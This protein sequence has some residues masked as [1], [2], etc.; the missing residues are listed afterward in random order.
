[1]ARIRRSRPYY[2]KN[3]GV[4]FSGG[5]P[6]LQAAFLA[7]LCDTC[8]AEGI[9]TAI[10]TAGL[11]LSSA[12]E[13]ALATCGL[14]LLDIKHPDPD[15]FRELTGASDR[16]MRDA[17]AFT[18]ANH[19]PTWIRQVIVPGWNDTPEDIEALAELV[20]DHPSRERVELLPYHTMGCAKWQALGRTSPF[21]ETPALDPDALASLQATLDRLLS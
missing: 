13:R 17:L 8:A 18:K 21:A 10:D 2:G 6:L 20:R 7:E 12:V 9:H 5:E 19:K 16:G 3:G 1:M 4:T 14:V 11:P 15:R